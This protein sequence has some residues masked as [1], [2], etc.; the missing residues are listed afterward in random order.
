M[1]GIGR[2]EKTLGIAWLRCLS[3]PFSNSQEEEKCDEL[4]LIHT[5]ARLRL[6][7]MISVLANQI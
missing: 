1:L 2:R 7:V 3:M 6:D 4:S 5:Y